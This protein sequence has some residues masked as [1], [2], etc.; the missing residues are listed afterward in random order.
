MCNDTYIWWKHGLVYHIYVKSFF[1]SNNDGIGDL[2]GIT[3]KLDYLCEL[4]MDAIWLSPVY[5]S[6]HYDGGYDITDY[7]AIDP[8]FGNMDDFDEL[9]SQC[10]SRGIKLILDLVMN[11]TSHLHPWFIES[12]SSL[13]NPKRDWYIWNQKKNNWFSF[14][15]GSAWTFDK[16]TKSY[17][18]HSFL[19]EQPDLNW[20]NEEMAE[21][22]FGNI[23][24]WL[25]KGVD[26][27]RLDVINVIAKDFRLR[28][29]PRVFKI[30]FFQK[31]KYNINRKY[32]FNIIEK[33]RTLVDTY[34]DRLIIGEIYMLPPGKSKRVLSF[35]TKNKKRLHLAFDFSL[36][37]KKFDA[38][39]Y[40]KY[41]N[42]WNK[43][44]ESAEGV[45]MVLSNHDLGRHINRNPFRL[46]KTQK[47]KIEI[48]YL[49]TSF[50]TPFIYYGDETGMR[51]ISVPKNKITDP[52]GIKFWP[53]Y[54]G[55]DKYRTPMQWD[56]SKNAGFSTD[57]PWLAIDKEFKNRCV[58]YQK[59]I[60]DSIF[61][62][63]NTLIRIRK[64]YKALH[65]GTWIPFIKGTNGVLA[66]HR[67][68]ESEEVLV[69]LNFR[70]KKTDIKLPDLNHY[71]ILVDTTALAHI[72]LA[73][74]SITINPFH[75]LVLLKQ[76]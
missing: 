76:N 69:I 38:G 74:E 39:T 28:P 57:E 72:G 20:R 37:F 56:M 16:T 41:L 27:F 40:Y 67:L 52:L 46:H 32:C 45:S 15:G 66:Y 42:K 75:G 11:H 48:M 61:N 10:H 73:Q 43:Y 71:E 19:K 55:R 64:K 47:A 60:P 49:L 13:N 65:M 35:V 18:L 63:Y 3:L 29:N 30:P 22:F 17:Y 24:F 54:S 62:L 59:N 6:A 50:A 4:G 7:K 51:N 23:R 5:P 2:K 25:D 8:Q 12:R 44:K 34:D 26:G 68:Y 14:F 58:E 53:F 9:L 70:N 33:L 36:T 1:D 31:V 21:A